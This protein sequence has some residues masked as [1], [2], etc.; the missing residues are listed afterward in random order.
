MMAE[1]GE[2][3]ANEASLFRA[4]TYPG[5]TVVDVGAHVGY[6]TLLAARSV[7]WHGRVIALEPDPVNAALLRENVRRNGLRNVSVLEAAAWHETTRLQLRRNAVNTGDNRVALTNIA[8]AETCEV[9]AIR[10]DE[11]LGGIPVTLV[12]VDAQGSDHFALQGMRETLQ[13]CWP[14]VFVEFCPRDIRASDTNPAEVVNGYKELGYEI[15][16]IG[17]DGVGAWQ[18]DEIVKAVEGYPYGVG[19]FV[20]RPSRAMM[21]A[22]TA[23]LN[24]R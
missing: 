18:A 13:R 17:F 11:I 22:G 6:Y 4:Y 5:A 2:W 21:R 23:A 9:S 15:S 7:G 8:D 10:L 19:V 14:V 12:K 16:L 24:T 1:T 20:L 3:E